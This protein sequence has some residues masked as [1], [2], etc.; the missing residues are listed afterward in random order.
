M[1]EQEEKEFM[2]KKKAREAKDILEKDFRELCKE[3]LKPF[4]DE[5]QAFRMKDENIR[6]D[7]RRRSKDR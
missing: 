3:A 6:K 7:E 2:E 1:R 4:K 5:E